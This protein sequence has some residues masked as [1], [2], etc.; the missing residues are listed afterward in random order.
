MT[1]FNPEDLKIR[2]KTWDLGNPQSYW[3]SAFSRNIGI[4]TRSDMDRL[5][6]A[7][8]AIAGMG[9]V[10]GSHAV[11]LARS[12]VGGFHLA[13][14]DRFEPA[15]INRQ[16]GARVTAFGRPKAE[17]VREDILLINPFA[18]VKLFVEGVTESNI[19]RFLDGV[20]AVLDGL[21]FFAIKARRLLFRRARERAISVVTAGPI[22]FGTPFMVFTPDGMSFDEYFDLTDRTS[23]VDSYIRFYL[24]M[25]PNGLHLRYTV[26]GRIR[27]EAKSGPSLSLACQTASGVAATET[28]RLLLG[29]PGLKPAPW[30][31]VFDP[32]LHVFKSNR[33]RWG[34]RGPFQRFKIW[35]V[36]RA[37][38]QRNDRF[39]LVPAEP[40][41]DRQG[42]VP[43]R[44][45][46][47]L[48]QAGLQ[49]PS[50]DNIQP[51]AFRVRDNQVDILLNA[52]ADPS[53]F[54][55]E[56]RAT[57]ISNGAV[58][59]NMA[60]AATAFG[61]DMNV[62][63][64]PAGQND[65]RVASVR[66][67][68]AQKTWDPLADLVWER[69]TNRRPYDR[70][71]I[72]LDTRDALVSAAEERGALLHLVA[73]RP[74]IESL[75]KAVYWADRAR[76]GLRECHQPLY[77]SIRKNAHEA[78]E[79]G[80]GFSFNNLMAGLDGRIFL[81][82]TRPWPVMDMANRIGIGNLVAN[83]GRD[84]I[85]NSSAVGLLT[86]PTDSASDF[87]QGG[88]AWQR[89][90]LT[91]TAHG[92]ALQPNA[93]LVFFWTVHRHCGE[94]AFPP[95]AAQPLRRAMEIARLWF[96]Q[97]HFEQEG[98]IMLFR[99][100]YAPPIPE[101]TFRRPLASFLR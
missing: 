30:N 42:P 43:T 40:A 50:G 62:E 29:R 5:A 83:I 65:E 56:Q 55:F 25:V 20:D 2:L 7:R 14:F 19:D 86:M 1:Y 72:P 89:V 95:A 78:R 15:N 26:P 66:F 98:L 100:G 16:Q 27:L 51:W 4:L 61:L 53:F 18:D 34:N 22:G 49:A 37:I 81:T 33:L 88:R 84:S 97:V 92:L 101:G 54:N 75:A 73:E 11:T 74:G 32:Y 10:G 63:S 31:F 99:L 21:D 17:V 87:L 82:L 39:R 38:Q 52:G 59:E 79:R 46:D 77:D 35:A 45:M 85:L 12:G 57:L 67:I 28:I 94:S 76:V 60:M 80:D 41:W 8:V 23:T 70:K 48:L 9:G 91:A 13:D 96:P 71:P 44:V 3:A 47:F 93:S 68:A 58:M 24:G 69:D 6:T 90:W 64:A 36:R